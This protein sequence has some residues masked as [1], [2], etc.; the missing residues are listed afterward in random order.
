MEVSVIKIFFFMIYVFYSAK[1]FAS[2]I[3]RSVFILLSN[4]VSEENVE[5]VKSNASK[6]L[7]ILSPP[8]VL[9]LQLK[10]FHHMG[11]NLTKVNRYVR[12]PLVLDIAPFTSSI[13]LVG[14]SFLFTLKPIV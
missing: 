6:Q 14:V 12:F 10:R 5:P 7:L 11:F 2:W 9:T 4:T 13:S 1:A 8:A 3:G